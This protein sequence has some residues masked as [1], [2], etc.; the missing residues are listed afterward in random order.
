MI[1]A[2]IVY[3]SNLLCSEK[4]YALHALAPLQ[5]SIFLLKQKVFYLLSVSVCVHY[6]TAE[7][8]GRIILCVLLIMI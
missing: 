4:L 2:L 8:T 7:N 5:E 1:H 6:S 3:S